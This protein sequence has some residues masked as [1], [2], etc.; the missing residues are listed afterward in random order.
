MIPKVTNNTTVNVI[1]NHIN[2]KYPKAQTNEIKKN[3]VLMSAA[4][5][6]AIEAAVLVNKSEKKEKQE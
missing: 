1:L 5:A 2:K 4:A 6:L 3:P